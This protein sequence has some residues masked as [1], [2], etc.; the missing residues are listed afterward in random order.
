M[1][2]NRT[3]KI[4]GIVLLIAA[5]VWPM[6]GLAERVTHRLVADVNGDGKIDVQDYH[7]IGLPWL[8]PDNGDPLAVFGPG[9]T[10]YDQTK[11]RIYQYDP[12]TASYLEYTPAMSP[13]I[14]GGG[15]WVL[16]AAD[17]QLSVVGTPIPTSESEP[18]LITIYPGWNIV[19]CPFLAGASTYDMYVSN[20]PR[21]TSWI[22]FQYNTWLDIQAWRYAPDGYHTVVSDPL[23]PASFAAWNAYWMYNYSAET[24]YLQIY[25]PYTPVPSPVGKGV[26]GSADASAAAS[27]VGIA[28]QVNEKWKAHGDKTLFLGLNPKASAGPDKWDCMSPPPIS[29]ETPRLYADHSAWAKRPGKYARDFRPLGS[30][31]VKYR[32]TLKV[33]NRDTAV[34]YVVKWRLQNFPTGTKVMLTDVAADRSFNMRARDRITVVVPA[35]RTVRNLMVVVEK[36]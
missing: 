29:N 7:L 30:Q 33:P 12:I 3:R 18:Y 21:A 13:V 16:T 35:H 36:N 24:A 20:D 14:P 23:Y 15:F 22:P 4:I 9:L 11:I 19:G 28:V 17:R 34:S 26:Q 5:L 2:A 6:D 8:I 25:R 32:I 10:A 1:T 31:P 27:T